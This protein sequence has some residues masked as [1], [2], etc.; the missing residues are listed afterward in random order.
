MME[1]QRKEEEIKEKQRDAGK[2][3]A[4]WYAPEFSIH[5]EHVGVRI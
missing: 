3:F 1:K 4:R 5:Y 2:M